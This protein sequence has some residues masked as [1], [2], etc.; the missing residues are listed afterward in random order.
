[1][2]RFGTSLTAILLAVLLLLDL[3]PSVRAA[4]PAPSAERTLAEAVLSDLPDTQYAPD[5]DEP[6]TFIVELAEPVAAT[7][8][9]TQA[10]SWRSRVKREILALTGAMSAGTTTRSRQDTVSFGFDYDTLLSGFSVRLPHRYAAQIRELPGVAAVYAV[11]RYRLPETQAVTTAYSN[12]GSQSSAGV[13]EAHAA[14]YT[15]AGQVIAVLDSALDLDHEAFAPLAP[16]V[17]QKLDSAQIQMMAGFLC[18]DYD[19]ETIPVWY[20]SKIPFQYDY[21][22]GD[23]D[24]N[25]DESGHGTHVS[26]IAAANGGSRIRGVAPDAQLVFM[27]IFSDHDKNTYDDV[28]LAALE[29]AAD[30]GVDV[31][32]MS[33]GADYGFSNYP[34]DETL[35]Y[36]QIYDRLRDMGV[37]IAAAAGNSDFASAAYGSAYPYASRPDA[38][39]VCQPGT[40]PACLC[41]ASFA[42][43]QSGSPAGIPSAFSSWGPTPDLRLK[44]EISAAGNSIFSALPQNQYGTESGSSMAAPQLAGLAALLRQAF[45][46]DSLVETLL[47]NTATPASGWSPLKQGAGMVNIAD[48]IRAMAYLTVAD[49]ERPKAELGD[50]PGPYSFHFTVHNCTD[51]QLEYELSATALTQKTQRRKGRWVFLSTSLD[52]TDTLVAVSFSDEAGQDVSRVTVPVDGSVTLQ[53]TIRPLDGFAAW[54]SDSGAV[55]GAFLDGYVRLTAAEGCGSNLGLPWL[56]FYGDWGAAGPLLDYAEETAPYA[57]T[58]AEETALGLNVFEYAA[59][60]SAPYTDLYAV[61]PNSADGLFTSVLSHTALLRSAQRVT[62]AVT[63]E[64]GGTPV[65]SESFGNVPRT[66]AVLDEESGVTK[67]TYA[68]SS[69][70]FS[71]FDCTACDPLPPE[72][73]YTYTVSALAFGAEEAETYSFSFYLDRTAPEIDYAITGAP[74]SRTLTVTFSDAHAVSAFQLRPFGDDPADWSFYT[75]IGAQAGRYTDVGSLYETVRWDEARGICV[76][77]V[78]LDQLLADLAGRGYTDLDYLCVEA[79]DY[80]L[81]RQSRVL[82][83][84]DEI[85]PVSVSLE[86]AEITLA[87]DETVQL[88]AAFVPAETTRTD[89]VWSS[90]RPEIASVDEHGAVTALARGNATI[91]A[92]SLREDGTEGPAAVCRVRVR[93]PGEP[94]LYAV[95]ILPAEHG[96][97]TADRQLAA[98]GESVLLTVEPESGWQLDALTVLGSSGDQ[99]SITE[100]ED[101]YAFAMPAEDVAVCAEFVSVEPLYTDVPADAWFDE[102]VTYVTEHSLMTGYGDRIFAPEDGF[103]RIQL[104]TVLARLD[105]AVIDGETWREDA[106]AWAVQT[107]ISDGTDPNG[108]ITREQFAAMLYRFAVYKN[109]DFGAAPADLSAFPDADKISAYAA[110]AMEWAVST[111]IIHGS[112]GLLLPQGTAIRAQAAAMLMRFHEKIP[113]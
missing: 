96:A 43:L 21:A 35:N 51:L 105:G 99:I 98:A 90:D 61:S 19:A 29:D 7:G 8:V 26:G 93:I 6:V 72:G 89:L 76:M 11:R 80:A 101:G 9:Q 95:E 63:P 39:T 12:A 15:G 45:K 85:W 28:I 24:V 112:D 32:N 67:Y 84:T 78:A 109:Y 97:V 22:D 31:I 49:S 54:L 81:N 62:V 2:K 38:G 18:A 103:T 66:S 88:H 3:A 30:L 91:R 42:S 52:C 74:G 110:D 48:A 55:N 64:A 59:G 69:A 111:G 57:V 37:F 17:A 107:G 92:V 27:K 113:D 16:D 4:S 50:G 87:P 73:F 47:M 36:E 94:E 71:G 5:P 70:D 33:L 82:P 25:N 56:A 104:M 1:M 14:G 58:T 79:Y 46:D 100:T 75:D 10:A 106:R 86:P 23:A 65:F 44:P 108:L 77:T 60:G 41:V 83:L 68:E 40:Y 20:S 34:E 102:A 13:T 53:V